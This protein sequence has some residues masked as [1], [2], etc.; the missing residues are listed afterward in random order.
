MVERIFQEHHIVCH[1]DEED[2]SN[3][4]NPV[5]SEDDGKGTQSIDYSNIFDEDDGEPLSSELVKEGVKTELKQ[6]E[7]Y[8]KT[9]RQEATSNLTRAGKNLWAQTVFANRDESATKHAALALQKRRYG[10][11]SGHR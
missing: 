9:G 7:D 4:E 11:P 10:S 5:E 1:V 6:L 8:W 3:W 2:D